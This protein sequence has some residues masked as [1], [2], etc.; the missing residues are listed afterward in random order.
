MLKCV[1]TF[2][3]IKKKPAQG[4][5]GEKEKERKER[6]EEGK[7]AFLR[8]VTEGSNELMREGAQSFQIRSM[9]KGCCHVRVASSDLSFVTQTSRI[10]RSPARANVC[11]F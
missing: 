6:K 9:K 5:E 4:R 3:P 10:G 8:K 7:D 2:P 11:A 1:G